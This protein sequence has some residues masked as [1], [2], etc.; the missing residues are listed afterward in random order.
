[1]EKKI[2]TEF[3]TRTAILLALAL[4]FQIGLKGIGQPIVGPL[5]NFVLII[6]VYTVGTLSGIIVGSLTPF[7][8]FI[9]GIMGFFPVVPVIIV[10]NIVYVFFFSFFRERFTRG[11]DV[12]GIILASF[13][14]YI[15]LAL[16]VKYI[17]VLFANVPPKVIAAFSIPQLYN[18]LIGGALA[19]LVKAFLPKSMFI[20]S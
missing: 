9:F 17:V 7:I 5:I 16:T 13:I 10:G 8:A 3:I 19:L 15:F 4:V 1:M 18:A 11:G 20:K 12:L 6:S 2:T 14:K